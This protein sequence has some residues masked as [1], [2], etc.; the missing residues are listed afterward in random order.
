MNRKSDTNNN[1]SSP[2]NM[3]QLLKQVENE[4]FDCRKSVLTSEEIEN[5]LNKA[6]TNLEKVL[7]LSKKY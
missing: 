7:T 2:N 1:I 5:K 6:I 4:C 3:Y